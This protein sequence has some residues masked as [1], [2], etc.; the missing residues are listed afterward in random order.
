MLSKHQK[1][2]FLFSGI[3]W[4]ICKTYSSHQNSQENRSKNKLVCVCV[5]ILLQRGEPF[6]LGSPILGRVIA[7]AHGANYCEPVTVPPPP[8]TSPA[9]TGDYAPYSLR[10]VCGFFIVPQNLY[11]QGL[12][13]LENLIICRWYYTLSPQLLKDPECLSGCLN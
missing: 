10:S 2:F 3:W 4:L 8:T 1:Y 12:R 6:Y 9:Q 5:S 7:T 11:E 13:R